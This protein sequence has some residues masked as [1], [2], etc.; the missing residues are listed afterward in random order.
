MTNTKESPTYSERMDSFP[1][2]NEELEKYE[3]EE[4]QKVMGQYFA[5]YFAMMKAMN[6]GRTSH[7]RVNSRGNPEPHRADGSPMTKPSRSSRSAVSRK[8]SK[9]ARLARVKSR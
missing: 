1:D 4:R 8:R 6:M 3:N 7:T 2:V 5:K 9:A